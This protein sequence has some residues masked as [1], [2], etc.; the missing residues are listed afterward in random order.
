MDTTN[1]NSRKVLHQLH[2]LIKAIDDAG[3][4]LL[5][6]E[7]DMGFS[8]FKILI[9]VK[10]KPQSS[11]ATIAACLNLTPPAI[12]R[13]VETMQKKGLITITVNPKN[14]R[15]HLLSLTTK[16]K[17]NLKESWHLLDTRFSAIMNV[18]ELK[19]QKQ[20]IYLLDKL[21]YQLMA[22]K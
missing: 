3:D 20:L 9:E 17:N 8:Q 10:D 19:E 6:S 14:R 15:E 16:G 1:S 5:H 7:M 13:H 2:S 22:C 21:S 12:S 11:Q 4:H 18:L